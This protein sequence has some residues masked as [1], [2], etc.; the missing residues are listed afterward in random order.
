M[1]GCRQKRLNTTW[2]IVI[3]NIWCCVFTFTHIFH[4]CLLFPTIVFDLLYSLPASFKKNPMSPRY[5]PPNRFKT[6]TS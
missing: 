5:K 6:L 1:V 3:Q 4:L 2:N